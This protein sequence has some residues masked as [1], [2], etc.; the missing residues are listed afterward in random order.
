MSPIAVIG[1]SCRLP[2]AADPAQFLRNLVAGRSSVTEVPRDRWQGATGFGGF[3]DGLDAFDSGFFGLSRREATW[4]DPQQRLLLELAWECVE[5]AAVSTA[6]V[7]GSRWGVFVGAGADDFRHRYLA[8]GSFD[9]YGHMGTSRTMLANRISYFFGL[10]G[11]SEVV[12]TG[13]SSSLVA[14]HRALSAVRAGECEAAIAGGVNLNLLRE[15]T[16]QIE[17]WGG[18]SPD[19]RCHTFD[20]RANGYVRGEGGGL[21]VLKPLEA[22]LRDGDA[23]HAVIRGSATANDGGPD[24]PGVPSAESQQDVIEAAHKAAGVSASDVVYVEL[25]GTGTPVGDPVEAKA[26][27]AAVGQARKVKVGSVKTNIGHLESAAGVAGLIKACLMIRDGVVPRSLNFVKSA[28]P[29]DELNL[30]VVTRC[31]DLVLHQHEVVGVSSFGMGGTNAHVVLGPPPAADQRGQAGEVVWCLS[32]RSPEALAELARRLLDHDPAG[33]TP[34]DVAWTLL[35]R[36]RWDHRA[37]VVGSTWDELRAGL[38]KVVAGNSFAVPQGW[39]GD[40]R[41]LSAAGRHLADGDPAPVLGLL[42]AARKVPSLPA[43]PFDRAEFPILPEVTVAAEVSTTGTPE[44]RAEWKDSPDRSWLVR[45][46]VEREL[47]DL[48]GEP[49][50]GNASAVAFH[51]LGVDSQAQ[52]ELMDRIN[53]STGLSLADTDV[54][55]CPTIDELTAHVNDRMGESCA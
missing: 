25:H 22:A 50:P 39:A 46:L 12:D 49:L 36:T 3:V 29:L 43:H 54:F 1:M 26:L 23:V 8:S 6:D 31:E 16:E 32:G 37:V 15:V 41:V 55:D 30:E 9:R 13:Q 27:G 24:L 48:L 2:G 14:V 11:P 33:H 17:L 42:G 47:A 34:A 19:G 28:L 38:A 21:V 35:H 4:M 5:D 7:R 52:M 51:D 20:E 44:F 45:S 53:N 10:R 18:L 40:V